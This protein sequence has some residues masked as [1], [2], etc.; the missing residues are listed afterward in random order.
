MTV[1]DIQ[2]KTLP[3]DLAALKES[4]E[5]AAED[6]TKEK[7][8]AISKVSSENSKSDT[9]ENKKADEEPEVAIPRP[10]G[11]KSWAEQEE[12]L[13]AHQVLELEPHEEALV[14]STNLNGVDNDTKEKNGVSNPKEKP[15]EDK[16]ESD[17]H[18]APQAGDTSPPREQESDALDKE[19]ETNVD[20]VAQSLGEVKID[21]TTP[22]SE[23]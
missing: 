2:N 5:K 18:A 4:A 11:G 1:S 6:L 22:N 16:N 13:Q 12:E 17:G 15:E 9:L 23:P 10:T 20:E 21:H 8:T 19:G 7:Q 3:D 14:E